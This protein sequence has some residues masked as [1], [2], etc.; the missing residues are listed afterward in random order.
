M[1][2]NPGAC[3]HRLSWTGLLTLVFLE[4]IKW[5]MACYICYMLL[6]PN[7]LGFDFMQSYGKF[8]IQLGM[9]YVK[10]NHGGFVFLIEFFKE[11][12]AINIFTQPSFPHDLF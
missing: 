7:S 1:V 5:V 9:L 10:K 2:E 4:N 6:M 3:K 11:V 8:L 12:I